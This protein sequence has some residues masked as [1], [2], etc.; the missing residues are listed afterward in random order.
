MINKHRKSGFLS[1]SHPPSFAL[2]LQLSLSLSFSLSL[3]LAICMCKYTHAHT[4]THAVPRKVATF[5]WEPN[6]FYERTEGGVD[7]F[8]VDID[9]VKTLGQVLNFSIEY[10]EPPRGRLGARSM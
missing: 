6:V 3:S 4:R 5:A 9:V 7:R 8:G 10:V 1:L 2:T